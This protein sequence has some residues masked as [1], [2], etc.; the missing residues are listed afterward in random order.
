MNIRIAKIEDLEAIVGIY[1][2][3]IAVGQKTADTEPF[4]VDNRK[5]WFEAHTPDNYPILIAEENDVVEGY[6]TISPYRPGRKAL[7][8]TAEVS[9]Y[10]HFDH[11]RRG[12]ASRLLEHA[13]CMCPLLGIKNLFAILIDSNVASVQLLEKYGFEKWGHMPQI[14]EFDGIEVGHL[15]YGL[16]IDKC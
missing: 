7:R 5:K 12:I 3:A 6:L 15:Y 4:T 1:N 10:V 8:H 14:A 9:Y 2:Q 11:H 16:R 13:I